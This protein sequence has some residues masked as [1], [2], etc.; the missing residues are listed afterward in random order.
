M[1]RHTAQ[2]PETILEALKD[3]ALSTFYLLVLVTQ[4]ITVPM[5]AVWLWVTDPVQSYEVV[6]VARPNQ[7][8]DYDGEFIITLHRLISE[9]ASYKGSGHHWMAFDKKTIE[10]KKM[11]LLHQ[12]WLTRLT[13]KE[14]ARCEHLERLTH[15]TGS[16]C[17]ACFQEAISA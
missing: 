15:K 6:S 1:R 7:P 5:A 8:Y 9:P 17:K 12:V 11:Q 16:L 14:R 4:P 3:L 13:P 2:P 10:F